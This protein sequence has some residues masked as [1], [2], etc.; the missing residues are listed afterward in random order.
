[1][2]PATLTGSN[3]NDSWAR[4]LSGK[5]GSMWWWTL[6]SLMTVAW[7]VTTPTN[8][9]AAQKYYYIHVGSFRAKKNAIKVAQGLKEEGQNRA[10]PGW[11]A[12]TLRYSVKAITELEYPDQHHYRTY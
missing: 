2:K 3:R 12:F 4:A 10:A 6:I 7:V 5:T 9:S 8:L 11:F 1:M